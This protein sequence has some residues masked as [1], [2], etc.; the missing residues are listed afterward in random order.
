VKEP[1]VA[2][3]KQDAATVAEAVSSELSEQILAQQKEYGQWVAAQQIFTPHGAL[4]Y[5]P[6]DAVPISNVERHQYDKLGWV[7][8]NGSKAHQELLEA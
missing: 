6:G 1:I 4:A 2:E 5:N 7:V 8:K 3:T